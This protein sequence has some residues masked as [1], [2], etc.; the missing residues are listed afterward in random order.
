VHRR[1][2]NRTK[3]KVGPGANSGSSATDF[4]WLRT[5]LI[6]TV[7]GLA[8]CHT[9]LDNLVRIIT[10]NPQATH[11]VKHYTYSSGDIS[12]GRHVTAR[13][14]ISSAWAIV[15]LCKFQA[16]HVSSGSSVL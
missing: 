9:R 4:E 8:N 11:S 3:P 6:S 15:A 10:R 16:R 5:G 7:V 14:F 1:V 12:T 2:I 13:I